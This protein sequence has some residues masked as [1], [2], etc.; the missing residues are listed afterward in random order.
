MNPRISFTDI[1]KQMEKPRE[2]QGLKS[3]KKSSF[4]NKASQVTIG[5]GGQWQRPKYDES[6]S[7]NNI[8]INEKMYSLMQSYIGDDKETIQGG[9]QYH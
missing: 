7:S 6:E 8:R 1:S 9:V 3:N 4:M 2:H 5:E